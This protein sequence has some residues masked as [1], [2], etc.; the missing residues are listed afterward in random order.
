MLKQCLL[1]SCILA[2]NTYAYATPEPVTEISSEITSSE[3]FEISIKVDKKNIE[4]KGISN[5]QYPLMIGSFKPE[6]SGSCNLS[7]FPDFMTVTVMPID[8][9]LN[10]SNNTN[11]LS[12][13]VVFNSVNY[14]KAKPFAYRSYQESDLCQL[15]QKHGDNAIHMS[16]SL[17]L[18]KPTTLELPTGDKIIFEAKEIK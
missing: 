4:A 17:N 8:V 12:T 5:F 2:A 6:K 16:Y 7:Q 15:F 10:K 9:K 3:K 13:I 14:D 18:D 1:A 11:M